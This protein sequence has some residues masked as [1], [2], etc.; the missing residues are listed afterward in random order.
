MDRLRCRPLVSGDLFGL[1]SQLFCMEGAIRT[2]QPSKQAVE[3]AKHLLESRLT[4]DVLQAALADAHS[5]GGDLQAAVEQL[6][7]QLCGSA[8]CGA[9]GRPV[10]DIA[11][12]DRGRSIPMRRCAS[13]PEG[14]S[15][16]T[17]VPLMCVHCRFPLTL[18]L[19]AGD[20][21][22][23][24]K[25]PSGPHAYATLLYGNKAEYFLGALVTGWSLQA[26]GSTID[27]LLLFTGDVPAPYLQTLERF[28]KLKEVEYLEGSPKL[29]KDYNKSRFKAVFT[30]LQALSCT[31]YAKVLMLDLDMLIRRNVDEL[32]DLHPP[33][34]LKRASGRGQPAHGAPFDAEVLWRSDRR[35]MNSGIN[36]GV[37]LLQPDARVY[38]RMVAEI[39]D[40]YHPEH[41]GTFGPEQDYLSRFYCT[42]IHGAWSHLHAKFNYQLM[43]PD[44][45]CSAAHRALD[46]DRDVA[47]AHYSGPRVKP[48]ELHRNT[49]LDVRKLLQDSTLQS[50]YKREQP[51]QRSDG[52][53][54]SSPQNR[55]RI[56]DGVLIVEKGEPAVLPENVRAV[57]WEWIAA[58]RACNDFLLGE[59][60]N[61]LDVIST[62]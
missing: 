2:A 45:Y 42:F 61:L 43:L 4:V 28:W 34:A 53:S 52:K 59:G 22:D 20:P 23:T 19:S 41:I 21:R 35:D 24:V 14:A 54:F 18:E 37:M 55:E 27:R 40:N 58:L 30:K 60:V 29:Y 1:Q 51:Q 49:P 17:E 44:D 32:F 10:V 56:M 16:C 7:I 8:S 13:C 39:G 9:I 15:E 5:K 26:S 48:W 31:E 12:R 6:R 25:T 36:A 11:M 57:M 33:A 3:R 46:I 47:I 50:C 62:V 38:E